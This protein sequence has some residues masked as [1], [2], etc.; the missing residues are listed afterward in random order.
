VKV[1]TDDPDRRPLLIIS[2]EKDHTVPPPIARSSFKH[3]E[4]NVESPTEFAEMPG[5]R[6]ALTIDHGWREVADAALAFIEKHA[7]AAKPSDPVDAR[8]GGRIRTAGLLLP[9]KNR[10][11]PPTSGDAAK[12]QVS[13]PVRVRSSTAEFR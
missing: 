3:Q 7:P 2:G 9:N 6:H 1:D 8:R 13:G 4:R 12:R 11:E 10:R 5:R